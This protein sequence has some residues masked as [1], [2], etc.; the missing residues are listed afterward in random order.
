MHGGMKHKVFTGSEELWLLNKLI[1]G[2]SGTSAAG[3]KV[4]VYS[5][6]LNWNV[7]RDRMEFLLEIR[8]SWMKF[9]GVQQHAT[10]MNEEVTI[11]PNRIQTKFYQILL[12]DKSDTSCGITRHEWSF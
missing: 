3:H 6:Q 2:N 7:G 10:T 11:L 9:Y 1:D 12:S 5:G 8:P 4:V